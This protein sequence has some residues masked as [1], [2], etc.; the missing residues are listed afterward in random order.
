MLV[1]P[2]TQEALRAA[3]F[4]TSAVV[5]AAAAAAA[6]AKP[7]A[8]A[9]S[10]RPKPKSGPVAKKPAA[11]KK[12]AAAKDKPAAKKIAGTTKKPQTAAKAKATKVASAEAKKKAAA[13]KKAA[14]AKKAEAKKAAAKA[15]KQAKDARRI[16]RAPSAYLL[17][18]KDQFAAERS[19]NPGKKSTELIKVL[20]AKYKAMS[21][22]DK[23]KYVSEAAKAKAGVQQ[24]RK[25]RKAANLA[26]TGL[27]SYVI[28]YTDKFPE[29]RAQHPELKVRELAAKVGQMWRA[30]PA[31]E[32]QQYKER[33]ARTKP[34]TKQ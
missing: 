2:F 1:A 33:A 8:K 15:A 17:F 16:K 30:A 28:Y 21:T 20:A 25:E 6:A 10:S 24:L 22:E 9:A 34:A 31:E 23:Q 29:I 11:T 19:A 12:P 27:T 18:V 13:S 3:Q 4:S 7:K 32:K 26:A 14:A 5:A